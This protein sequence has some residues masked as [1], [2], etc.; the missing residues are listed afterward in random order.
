MQDFAEA[1]AAW[2][3][4]RPEAVCGQAARELRAAL[5]QNQAPATRD[6]GPEPKALAYLHPLLASADRSE[7]AEP[8]AAAAPDLDWLEPPAGELEQYLGGRNCATQLVGPAEMAASAGIRFGTFLIAPDAHYPRHVHGAEELYLIIAGSGR[9]S[10]DGEPYVRHGPGE[11]VHTHSWQP[12]AI[13]TGDEALLMAWIWMGD[14]SFES[15]RMEAELADPEG[16][17]P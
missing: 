15:Y 5:S 9:W 7:L 4:E 17:A 11:V 12:H 16:A 10:Y 8:L 13:R 1:C 14:I 2:L 3:S 6:E